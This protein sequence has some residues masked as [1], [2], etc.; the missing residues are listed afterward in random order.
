MI[1]LRWP[2]YITSSCGLTLFVWVLIAE[3][4]GRLFS[5]ATFDWIFH[6]GVTLKCAKKAN[7][8][9]SS[10]LLERKCHHDL[11]GLPGP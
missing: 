1:G 3:K 8:Q 6:L 2:G 9:R 11:E 7:K 4:I 5:K 10:A